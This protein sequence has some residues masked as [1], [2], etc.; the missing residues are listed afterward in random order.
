MGLSCCTVWFLD[1]WLHYTLV[2][3]KAKTAVYNI[4]ASAIRWMDE[5]RF[6]AV[7]YNCCKPANASSY[8]LSFTC[9]FSSNHLDHKGAKEKREREAN[10]RLGP[11]CVSA[12]MDSSAARRIQGPLSARAAKKKEK[13]KRLGHAR[14]FLFSSLTSRKSPRT[15]KYIRKIDEAALLIP[16]TVVGL[17][18]AVVVCRSFTHCWTPRAHI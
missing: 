12:A 16:S 18:E 7:G 3:S 6:I 15:G 2:H 11:R 17:W 10:A 4:S 8:P 9:R 5:E 13:K 1:G 14:V